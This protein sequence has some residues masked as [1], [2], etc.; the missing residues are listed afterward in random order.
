MSLEL[1]KTKEIRPAKLEQL[2]LNLKPVPMTD[3]IKKLN[4]NLLRPDPQDLNILVLLFCQEPQNMEQI[5][6]QHLGVI[7]CS[8]WNNNSMYAKELKKYF[9]DE[10]FIENMI[11]MSKKFYIFN[12][13]LQRLIL[14]DNADNLD[15]SEETSHQKLK[16]CISQI[17]LSGKEKHEYKQLSELCGLE[18]GNKKITKKFIKECVDNKLH[19]ER[20]WKQKKFLITERIRKQYIAKLMNSFDE[21]FFTNIDKSTSPFSN[22]LAITFALTVVLDYHRIEYLTDNQ[23]GKLTEKLEILLNIVDKKRNKF[24]QK[25]L[26]EKMNTILG[27]P[28]DW[29]KLPEI[30]QKAI[31]IYKRLAGLVKF[32]YFEIIAQIIYETDN[33]LEEHSRRLL[34]NRTIFWMNYANQISDIR[35]FIPESKLKRIKKNKEK[36]ERG[37]YKISDEFLKQI[38]IVDKDSEVCIIWLANLTVVE[39]FRGSNNDTLILGKIPDIQQSEK[40]LKLDFSFINKLKE[41]SIIRVRHIYLWQKYLSKWF[42]KEHNISIDNVK[43]DDICFRI[44]K[45]KGE[46]DAYFMGSFT[47]AILDNSPDYKNCIVY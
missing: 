28:A 27:N 25:P 34:R 23:K 37:N 45:S 32:R 40:R 24:L 30:S 35:I 4:F 10:N 38:G 18:A 3:D 1:R 46:F 14:S 6:L 43:E 15:N 33:T 7:I 41:N 21:Y 11:K 5:Y 22:E 44:P 26:F 16:Q 8:S 42:Y 13:A 36:Y 19:P 31:E 17:L 47:E 29:S 12:L 9:F 2:A 39:F 20:L